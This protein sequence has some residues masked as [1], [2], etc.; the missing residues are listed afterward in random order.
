MELNRILVAVN[1]IG[2]RDAA[3]GRALSLARSF[4]AELYVLH[5]VP[6]NQR[7]STR[8]SDRLE[9]M[10]D[11]RKR[12]EDAGVRVR[13][14]EQHGDPAEL[15]GLHADARAADLIVMGGEARRGRGSPRSVV[16]ER[17]IRRTTVP[18][19]V[20]ASDKPDGLVPFRRVLVALD[21]SPMS[22]D[23]LKGAVA[24]AAPDAA[25]TMLHTATGVE[26]ADAGQ[27]PSRWTVPEFRAHILNDARASLEGL[28]SDV[29]TALDTRVQ[30]STGSA[31]RTIL[32]RAADVEADLV[33]VGRSRSFKLLGSTALRVLRK[34]DRALLVIPS[35]DRLTARVE[36]GRAA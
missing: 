3:F 16:A 9:R 14:V 36:R 1:L 30:V 29:P 27:S 12:G 6:P 21:L 2:D 33:V 11:M 24:L 26:S 35:A 34:N 15:I 17:M 22:T 23:V 7:F 10:A 4:K 25:L 8:A 5:A 18:T 28:V 31:A 32:D 20:V 19:L 13:T